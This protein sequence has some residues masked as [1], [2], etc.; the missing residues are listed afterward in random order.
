MSFQGFI[1]ELIASSH[2]NIDKLTWEYKCSSRLYVDKAIAYHKKIYSGDLYQP[3]QVK[4]IQF[5]D[6][7]D[8]NKGVWVVKIINNSPI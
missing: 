7:V 1:P 5:Q 8:G 4:M 3:I 2:D 6:W